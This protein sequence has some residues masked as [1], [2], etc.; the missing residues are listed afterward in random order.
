MSKRKMRSIYVLY[1]AWLCISM[2][3]LFFT[4]DAAPARDTYAEKM[5]PAGA[6][7]VIL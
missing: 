6:D 1:S 4:K 5:F 2:S 7:D 3:C